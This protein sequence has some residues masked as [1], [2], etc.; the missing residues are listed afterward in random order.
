MCTE[1]LPVT[2]DS[3]ATFAPILGSYPYALNT[4]ESW[5]RLPDTGTPS[6]VYFSWEVIGMDAGVLTVLVSVLVVYHL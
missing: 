5:Y 6:T 4:C 1:F 3:L 2:V